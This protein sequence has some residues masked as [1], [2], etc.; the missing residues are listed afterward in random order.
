MKVKDYH[1]SRHTTNSFIKEGESIFIVIW[2][3]QSLTAVI[4]LNRPSGF[5]IT[6]FSSREPGEAEKL[7]PFQKKNRVPQVAV[8][9][10]TSI[11]LRSW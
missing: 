4:R 9:W 10:L 3:A 7:F 8:G 6:Y 11:T 2:L 5:T 1:L